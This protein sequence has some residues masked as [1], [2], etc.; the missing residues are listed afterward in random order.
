MKP[1]VA[2]CFI[3]LLAG[4]ASTPQSSST[5]PAQSATAPAV[6]AVGT[7]SL[8]TLTHADLQAAAKYATDH[9]YPA[10]AAMWQALEAQLTAAE[11]QVAACRAAIDAAMPKPSKSGEVVGM[12]T[13][14]EIAAE[15]VGQGVPASVKIN[16]EP[17]VIP[18]G[19]LPVPKLP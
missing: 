18:T 17:I 4:C 5:A 14:V 12:F 13:L 6:G 1:I 2:L 15:A 19:L 3:S 8:K 9:A 16:C 10:R 7:T 11:N